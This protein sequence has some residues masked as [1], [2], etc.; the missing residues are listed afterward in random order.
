MHYVFADTGAE[1]ISV[2]TLAFRTREE[3]VDSLARA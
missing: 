1:L 2:N 3:T